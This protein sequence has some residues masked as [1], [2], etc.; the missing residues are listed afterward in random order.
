MQ[1]RDYRT[2]SYVIPLHPFHSPLPLSF[3]VLLSP[4]RLPR[5]HLKIRQE[6]LLRAKINNIPTNV[7][8]LMLSPFSLA[9]R[10]LEWLTTLLDLVITTWDD[11]T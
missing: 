3:Q 6:T 10:A 2:H 11:C 9:D 5:R 1:L 4:P 7:I 8:R